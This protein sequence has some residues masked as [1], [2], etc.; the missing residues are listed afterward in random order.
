[1]DCIAGTLCCS[2]VTA[3]PN[4]DI[5]RDNAFDDKRAKQHIDEKNGCLCV[6]PGSHKGDLYKHEYPNDGIVNK[7]YHGIQGSCSRSALTSKFCHTHGF[8]VDSKYDC[9]SKGS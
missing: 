4:I 8:M 6:I 3:Y 1:V 2:R 9:R 5:E 7:A